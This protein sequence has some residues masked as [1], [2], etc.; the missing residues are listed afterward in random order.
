MQ[1]R[2]IKIDDCLHEKLSNL[3]FLFIRS[4]RTT[5]DYITYSKV[6]F[7]ETCQKMRD[8]FIDG[9]HAHRTFSFFF[10]SSSSRSNFN[11]NLNLEMLISYRTNSYTLYS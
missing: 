2:D 3:A 10:F 7:K 6:A 9:T 4:D 11:E 1:T 8:R 5:L